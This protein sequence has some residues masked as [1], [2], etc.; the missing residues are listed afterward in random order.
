MNMRSFQGANFTGFL[1]QAFR[2]QTLNADGKVRG[3]ILSGQ[4]FGIHR[5]TGR[6]TTV[7]LYIPAKKCTRTYYAKDLYFKGQAEELRPSVPEKGGAHD[8]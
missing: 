7:S 6:A 8:S 1:G 5:G 4:V 3:P 2:F